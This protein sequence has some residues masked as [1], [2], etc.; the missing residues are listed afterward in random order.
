MKNTSLIAKVTITCIFLFYVISINAQCNIGGAVVSSIVNEPTYGNVYYLDNGYVKLG[1]G[2]EYGGAITHISVPTAGIT[3]MV[4]NYDHGRQLVPDLYMAPE[5]YNTNGNYS[6][7]H[8]HG[9]RYNVTLAG[10]WFGN[11]SNIESFTPITDGVK[12]IMTPLVW[13]LTN[14]K[15][16]IKFVIYYT[17]VGR[18]IDVRYEV[19]NNR[20][21]FYNFTFKNKTNFG[22]A[23]FLTGVYHN[24]WTYDGGSPGSN[25]P[26]TQVT[27]NQN[28]GSA[29]AG[30]NVTE[31]WAALLNNS[32]F[33]V[34]MYDSNTDYTNAEVLNVSSNSTNEFANE[35][36]MLEP[37]DQWVFNNGDTLV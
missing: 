16:E 37:A 2:M 20:T 22:I 9:G 27:L 8:W 24:F 28:G 5:N 11:T 31:H 23:M 6:K 17:L 35:F 15:S 10:D 13:N 3:N 32:Q 30:S 21:D 12:I 36:G 18:K 14:I 7:A 19:I 26:A 33:G 1:I 34:A 4:N 25:L 29:S